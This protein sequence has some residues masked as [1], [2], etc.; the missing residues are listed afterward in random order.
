MC[1]RIPEASACKLTTRISVT[2]IQ[3]TWQG[4]L[5]AWQ[6]CLKM[7]EMEL[8]LLTHGLRGGMSMIGNRFSKANNPYVPDYKP[9]QQNSYVMHY[10]GNNLYGWAMLQLFQTLT[11]E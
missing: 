1:L 6:G 9:T 10:D 5:L 3:V 2:S 4:C 7:T 8:E 11:K